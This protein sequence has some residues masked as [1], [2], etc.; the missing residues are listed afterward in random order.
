MPTSGTAGRNSPNAIRCY[1]ETLALEN[2]RVLCALNIDGYATNLALR[3][4]AEGDAIIVA[5]V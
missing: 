4:K 2:Q 1:L 3:F 5:T